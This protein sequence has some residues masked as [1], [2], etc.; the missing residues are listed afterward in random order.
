MTD[1]RGMCNY[2]C[3]TIHWFCKSTNV[4]YPNK[5]KFTI[6][7]DSVFRMHCNKNKNINKNKNV[8]H[9]F[10]YISFFSNK[11]STNTEV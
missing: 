11:V 5:P 4:L 6:K 2:L 1:C 10:N 3:K 7:T 8:N 9:G